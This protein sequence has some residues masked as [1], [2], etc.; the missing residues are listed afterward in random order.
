MEQLL[1]M[2]MD[3]GL[4][5]AVGQMDALL[6]AAERAAVGASGGRRPRGR[7]LRGLRLGQR[8]GRGS[9]TGSTVIGTW[10]GLASV[11]PAF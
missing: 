5:Q 10:R 3:E 7:G 8:P 2:G 9:S 11:M 4:R 6:A 1:A